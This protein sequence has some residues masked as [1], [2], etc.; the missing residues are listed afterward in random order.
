[1]CTI[2]VASDGKITLVGNEDFFDP[3]TKVWYIPREGGEIEGKSFHTG[4]YGRVYFRYSD[5]FPQGGMNGERPVFHYT[6][7]PPLAITKSLNKPMFPGD[8]WTL[9]DHLWA[10]CATV[11]EALAEL[12]KYNMTGFE[13]CLPAHG[14][15]EWGCSTVRRR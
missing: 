3:F 4:K 11:K 9:P 2:F 13:R 5:L 10:P 1:M 8:P 7:Q 15:P 6:A 14:R 12:D